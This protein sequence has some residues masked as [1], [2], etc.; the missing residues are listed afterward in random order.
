L[1]DEV[2]TSVVV[3]DGGCTGVGRRTVL[4]LR[5]SRDDALAVHVGLFA[6]PDHPALPRGEWVVLRDFLRYGLEASTGDGCVRL[7]PTPDGEHV[8][9]WLLSHGRR[10]AASLPAR[11]VAEFLDAT[12]RIV[13][14]GE[15]RSDDALDDVIERLL[16]A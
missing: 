5:W 11:T 12:E 10:Q 4:T 13:P 15:E 3:V 16:R 9:F 6:E 8:R 2:T 7:E 14:S 1:T